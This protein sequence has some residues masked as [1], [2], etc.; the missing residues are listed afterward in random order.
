MVFC[1]L[2]DLIIIINLTYT[3]SYSSLL[4]ENVAELLPSTIKSSS[5]SPPPTPPKDPSYRSQS[6]ELA[7]DRVLLHQHYGDQLTHRLKT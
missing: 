4:T 5:Y 6:N 3:A 1:K 2:I 7:N